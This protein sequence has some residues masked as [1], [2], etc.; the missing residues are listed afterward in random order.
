MK[1]NRLFQIGAIGATMWLMACTSTDT[2]DGY[3]Q[4]QEESIQSIK[5]IAH[6]FV[7]ADNGSRT[8]VEMGVDGADFKWSENDTIG[9][10]PNMGYQVAFPMQS[11]AGSETAEFSGG[12]W[13]LKAISSYS[14]YYPFQY[15]NRSHTHIAVSYLGQLQNGD[16][17][18]DH[19]G[20]YDYMAAAAT[21]PEENKVTFDFQHLGALLQWKLKIPVLA[22]LSSVS[23]KA[24][25]P[26]FMTKGILNL[27][28]SRPVIES[29]ENDTIINLDLNDI[30]TN[31]TGQ[32]IIVYMMIPPTNLTGKKYNVEIYNDSG[33]KATAE[34]DGQNFEAGKMYSMSVE[35]T[36]FVEAA[37]LVDEYRGKVVSHEGGKVTLEAFSNKKNRYFISEGAKEWITVESL[38]SSSM[39]VYVDENRS[40]ST[41]RGFVIIKNMITKEA[42]EYAIL[43]GGHNSYA[44]TESNGRMPIGILTSNYPATSEE[45]GLGM[46]V[47]K[48]LE[49]YFEANTNNTL[50]LDWEGPYAITVQSLVFGR[51]GGDG[52]VCNYT[53]HV[54]TDGTDWHGL[55]WG[56]VG[57]GYVEGQHTYDSRAFSYHSRFFRFVIEDCFGDS[58]VRVPEFGLTQDTDVVVDPQ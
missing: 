9:I 27:Q 54:A 2:V 49:T 14:A 35:F 38:K 21:V 51:F 1:K 31:R 58:V 12:G 4:L 25:E 16:G 32:E 3:S 45:H 10:F 5:V 44:I 56:V 22:T 8:S 33:H 57:G 28:K 48:N 17:N 11:G 23:L 7:R 52:G 53:M 24:D 15:D 34:L 29:C 55:G 6:D 46:L 18:A 20:E 26:L 43:Q 30:K 36:E 41:R 42:V 50:Y 19:I 13:A 47:D 40:D 39:I 37:I